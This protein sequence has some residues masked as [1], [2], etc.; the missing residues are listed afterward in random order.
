MSFWAST[1]AW[2]PS[3]LAWASAERLG[4]ALLNEYGPWIDSWPKIRYPSIE[5]FVYLIS[6][7]CCCQPP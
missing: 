1:A 6:R 4:K 7:C 3:T 5:M 2:K